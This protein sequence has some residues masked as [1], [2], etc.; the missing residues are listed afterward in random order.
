VFIL[1]DDYGSATS[2]A[3]IPGIMPVRLRGINGWRVT[4]SRR[5]NSLSQLSCGVRTLNS[6]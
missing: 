5:I 2:V 3:I 1:L 6:I 4:E